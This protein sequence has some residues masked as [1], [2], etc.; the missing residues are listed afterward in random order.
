MVLVYIGDGGPASFVSDP[1]FY[2][3]GAAAY[4]ILPVNRKA[5]PLKLP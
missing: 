1:L 5:T 2:G 3:P 4:F